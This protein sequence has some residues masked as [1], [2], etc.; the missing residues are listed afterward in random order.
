MVKI[1]E[2][3]ETIYQQITKKRVEIIPLQESINRVIAREYRAKLNLPSFDNS[4]MDGYALSCLS[5]GVRL[6]DETIYAGDDKE[7][8]LYDDEAIR[9][10]TGARVPFGCVAVIPQEKVN[11][12]SDRLVFDEIKAGANIRKIGEDVLKDSKLISKG[13]K[14]NGYDIALLASQ[15]IGYV[16]VYQKPKVTILSSGEELKAFYEPILSHQIYNSNTPM[17]YARAKELGA[18][19]TFLNT[20]KDNEESLKEAINMALTS[21]LIITTG[22]ASVGDKDFTIS[23]LKALGMEFLFHKVDIKPGKPTSLGKIG[24]SFI[25]I[26]AGNP[27]AAMVNFELFVRPLILKLSNDS[28]FYHQLIET[29]VASDGYKIKRARDGVILGFWNGRFFKPLSKQD[30]FMISP[31]SLANAMLVLKSSKEELN[32]SVKIIHLELQS[33]IFEDILN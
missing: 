18:D 1:D 29:K 21:D 20:S 19:V 25:A 12:D 7:Y 33:D 13:K 10:M 17:F 11:I 22:G 3:L 14:L 8:S 4:A 2:A 5:S 26:L 30:P 6:R 28:F 27:L 32:E 16:E 31:L 24:D 23:A 9:I 15:G